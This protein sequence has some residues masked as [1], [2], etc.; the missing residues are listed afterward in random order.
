MSA[1]SIKIASS[2]ELRQAIPDFPD[3][4]L[5]FTAKF[6]SSDTDPFVVAVS[7]DNG[8]GFTVEL[9]EL[10]RDLLFEGM[11]RRVDAG[12]VHMV[13]VEHDGAQFVFLARPTPEEELIQYEIS[14]ADLKRFFD[15]SATYVERGKQGLNLDDEGEQSCQQYLDGLV[16]RAFE[17]GDEI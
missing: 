7:V 9:F 11:S 2:V 1:E 14:L 16:E 15:K 4:W 13:P 8:R 6:V 17:D 12:L 3:L 5:S 10:D